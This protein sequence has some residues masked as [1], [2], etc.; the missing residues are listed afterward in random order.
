MHKLLQK[1]SENIIISS[2]LCV[3]TDTKTKSDIVKVVVGSV[4]LLSSVK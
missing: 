2:P 4:E 3:T 1:T